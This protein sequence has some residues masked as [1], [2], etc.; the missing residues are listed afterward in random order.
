MRID[1]NITFDGDKS[2]FIDARALLN[3]ND[4]SEYFNAQSRTT[5]HHNIITL[6][7]FSRC[8][9]GI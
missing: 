3:F 8:D 5:P 9:F 2:A 1:E 6:R 7:A 4:F